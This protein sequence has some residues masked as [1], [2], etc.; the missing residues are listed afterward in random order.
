MVGSKKR[1]IIL[2]LIFF[3]AGFL[4]L[5]DLNHSPLFG[6]GEAYEEKTIFYSFTKSFSR[7][8]S[9]KTFN[10]ASSTIPIV[11]SSLF[12]SFF[13]DQLHVRLASVFAN[14]VGLLFFYLFVKEL[15]GSRT[16]LILLFFAS[17][18][19]TFVFLNRPGIIDSGVL[20]FFTSTLLYLFAKHHRT[21][22]KV[23]AFLFSVFAGVGVSYQMSFLIVGIPLTLCLIFSLLKNRAFQTFLAIMVLGIVF[24]AP[25]VL[26]IHQDFPKPY[27]PRK[28]RFD[29]F[30]NRLKGFYEYLC[31]PVSFWSAY[32]SELYD[33]QHEN[34]YVIS[35]ALNL[36]PLSLFFLCGHDN[37]SNKLILFLLFSGLFLSCLTALVRGSDYLSYFHITCLFPV[38][39]YA[40]FRALARENNRL[41][42]PVFGFIHLFTSVQLIVFKTV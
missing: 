5:Y 11:Y 2:S 18:F 40:C 29:V 1:L 17:V 20:P 22:K 35:T 37:A 41:L 14:L 8:N 25:L 26:S 10:S 12:H 24:S 6:E 13:P 15:D 27:G 4:R 21:K 39:N 16:A 19:P 33:Y 38:L 42:A 9:L 31:L 36:I 23:H 28:V 32:R 30:K 3:A 34:Y 7:T